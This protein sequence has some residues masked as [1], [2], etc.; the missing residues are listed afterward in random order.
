MFNRGESIE[1]SVNYRTLFVCRTI[2][3]MFFS[4]KDIKA[5]NDLSSEER[6][7]VVAREKQKFSAPQRLVINILK[8]ILYIP[9]FYFLAQQQWALT[10]IC[11]VVMAL[12]YPLIL[13]P[14]TYFFISRQLE[15]SQ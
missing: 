1:Y 3:Y 4:S 8:L 9:F 7:A 11:F 12:A 5:L 2:I 6:M 13:S 10:L 14:L 15:N